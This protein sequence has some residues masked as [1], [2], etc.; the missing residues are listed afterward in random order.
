MSDALV[1]MESKEIEKMSHEQLAQWAEQKSRQIVERIETAV[2]KAEVAKRDAEEA[3]NIEIKWYQS[4][5]KKVNATSDAL[6]KANEAIADL[7]SL[8]KEAIQFSQT[9]TSLSNA[10]QQ[11]L[12]KMIEEGITDANG[13]VRTVSEGAAQFV[14]K[15]Q[16][17]AARFSARQKQIEELQA[18]YG[19]KVFE[20][21]QRSEKA[22]HELRKELRELES[23][24]SANLEKLT[25]L[26]DKR[27]QEVHSQSVENDKLHDR[28]LAE[29]KARNAELN[30]KSDANDTEHARL[31]C[32]LEIKYAT[33]EAQLTKHRPSLFHITISTIAFG[34][35][36][37]SLIMQWQS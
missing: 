35:G 13:Q 6:V 5:K 34:L 16:N 2:E 4:S 15:V 20:L 19:N 9:N 28:L 25:S 8:V 18:E 12:S 29:L 24:Y 33:I 22:D 17:E 3:K 31:L 32:E 10:V 27:V 21:Q 37:A 36:A 30:E 23:N 7:H 1:T 26:I 14:A 11:A